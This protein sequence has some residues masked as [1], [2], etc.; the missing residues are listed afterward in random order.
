M[1][2]KYVKS[3]GLVS[4]I[5]FCFISVFLPAIKDQSGPNFLTTF[6]ENVDDNFY[7]IRMKSA[8]D[9]NWKSKNIS[10]V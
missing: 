5:I 3:I 10:T 9:K 8:L 4:I 6:S 1:I 7:D 2:S